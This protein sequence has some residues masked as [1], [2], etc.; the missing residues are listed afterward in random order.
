[1]KL[2][3]RD[4]E[5]FLLRALPLDVAVRWAAKLS[6]AERHMLIESMRQEALTVQQMADRII[7]A[8]QSSNE[9]DLE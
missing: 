6:G 9:E 8:E 1:M 5:T 4:V 3:T 7:A 2:T